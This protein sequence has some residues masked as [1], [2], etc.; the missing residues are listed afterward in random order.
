VPTGVVG[1]CA[2]RQRDFFNAT[3]PSGTSASWGY[4]AVPGGGGFTLAGQARVTPDGVLSNT[5]GL[6]PLFVIDFEAT[7]CDALAG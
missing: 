3:G 7:L 2:E 4:V 1:K 6:A 5:H